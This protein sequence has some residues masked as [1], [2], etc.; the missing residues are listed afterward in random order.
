MAD[1][2]ILICESNGEVE[3]AIYNK[4]KFKIISITNLILGSCQIGS[5][6]V[7]YLSD[8]LKSNTTI[9]TLYLRENNIGSGG[10]KYLCDSLKSNSTITTLFL[11]S[12]NIGSEGFKYLSDTLKNNTT[13]TAL[14]LRA[15]Q[16][17]KQLQEA[18]GTE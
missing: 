16:C 1:Q 9:T 7:K 5:E 11:G 4:R 8:S 18:L 3:N 17:C 14:D 13:I 10:V 15:N 2:N 6:G 12:N